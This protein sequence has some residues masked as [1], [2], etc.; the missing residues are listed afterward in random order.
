MPSS[1]VSSSLVAIRRGRPSGS[2]DLAF[3]EGVIFV[4]ML[5]DSYSMNPS[6]AARRTITQELKSCDSILGL[7]SSWLCVSIKKFQPDTVFREMKVSGA[8]L[9][10]TLEAF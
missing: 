3:I 4:V 2:R 10:Q 6:K 1:S 8:S 9:S 5:A 7:S